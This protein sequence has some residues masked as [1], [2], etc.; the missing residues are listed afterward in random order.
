ML[1][2]WMG[3]FT[4]LSFILNL[5]V[6]IL[7]FCFIILPKFLFYHLP[8]AIVKFV[9]I[10]WNFLK[11]CW[12]WIKMACMAIFKPKQYKAMKKNSE[13]LMKKKESKQ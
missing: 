12:F 3:I 6:Y 10:V 9:K 4:A 1:Q 5:I 2:I 7:K 8:L 13:M 11:T